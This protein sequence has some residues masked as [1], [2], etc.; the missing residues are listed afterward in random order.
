[1]VD[2][3]A[4]GL[5]GRHIGGGTEDHPGLGHR[6]GDGWGIEDVLF[7][8]RVAGVS[9]CETEVENFELAL[10][11]DLDVRGF[12]VAVDN[13]LLVGRG[14]AVGELH[15]QGDGLVKGEGA[16]LEPLAEILALDQLHHQEAVLTVLLEAV[17]TGDVGVLQRCQGSRF[18]LESGD[19]FG[20]GTDVFREDLDR[21]LTIELGVVGSVDLT[22]AAAAERR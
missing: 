9:P 4:P 22:H 17:D 21:D 10:G 16:R 8:V 15:R 7:G 1:L 11:G 14:E 3:L 12:E 6:S 2:R 20:V 5:L 13:A 19:S 18:A